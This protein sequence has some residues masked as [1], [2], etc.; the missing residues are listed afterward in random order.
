MKSTMQKMGTISK[1]LLLLGILFSF[2][3]F[4]GGFVSW[5]LFYSMLPILLYVLILP[6]YPIHYWEVYR[7]I[8][9]R[10]LHAGNKIDIRITIKRK[11]RFPILFLIIKE[12]LPETLQF[13]HV[14][15]KQY[16][17]L[18]IQNY[19]KNRRLRKI[20]YLG[21]RKEITFT[22]TLD[23]LPRGKHRLRNL[24]LMIGDP[25]GLTE[26]K[27]PFQ[28]ED[29][30]IVYPA[31]HPMVLSHSAITMEEEASSRYFRDDL[32]SNIVSGVRDYTPGD[33][34][35]W[36]DWK[37]SARKNKII[38]KEFEQEKNS[39]LVIVLDVNGINPGQQLLFE[40]ALEWTNSILHQVQ[41]T[42][43]QLSVYIWHHEVKYFSPSTI[44]YHYPVIQ[45][46][47]ATLQQRKQG[48][49]VRNNM[50]IQELSKGA[51]MLC[52]TCSL[53]EKIV[54]RFINWKKQHTMITVCYLTSESERNEKNQLFVQSLRVHDIKVQTITEKQLAKE[55]W[56]V[57]PSL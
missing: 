57:N 41:K 30:F 36:I 44:N 32:R 11:Y 49:T 38:T 19:K 42:D 35:S 43:Q 18:N 25:F 24:T 22:Y 28:V 5:F 37:A 54:N 40:A 13:Q 52:I 55:Q 46:Y 3:M 51:N 48:T 12:E 2:A 9:N 33:R 53:D 6:F 50:A 29:D 17:S 23:H 4:Q 26:I 39:D 14:K 21:F 45:H 20:I 16:Q 8:A 56:E 47:F 34:F 7:E 10:Y 31:V 1:I 15:I 27:H